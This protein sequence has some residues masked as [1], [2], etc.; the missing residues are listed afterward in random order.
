MKRYT[1]WTC[2]FT[3][4]EKGP[5]MPLLDMMRKDPRFGV[6][7]YNFTGKNITLDFLS[8]HFAAVEPDAV[9]CGF[10]RPEMVPVAYAAYHANIPVAQIFA[11]DLAGGAW[12]DADRFAISQYASMLFVSG[13]AQK[14]RLEKA[15]SWR[16]EMNDMPEIVLSGATH[17]DDLDM[18]PPP[19]SC[20]AKDYNVV[21]YNPPSRL[22]AEGIKKELDEILGLVEDDITLWFEPN[23]DRLSDMI[24]DYVGA[25]EKKNI[26][27]RKNLDRNRF[28][29]YLMYC[30]KFIG[31]SSAMFYEGR[32]FPCEK[33]QVGVRNAY[34]EP[35]EP[36][37]ARAGASKNISEGLYNYLERKNAGVD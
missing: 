13:K 7:S 29:G 27:F 6:M 23:G 8:E 30:K 22:D 26:V 1:I 35:M 31:N 33:V 18:V 37:Y 20:I 19:A 9:I 28:L 2:Y 4:S 32:A 21:L 5:L 36:G 10:D 16:K 11:G 17:F 34:R 15:L 14:R 24:M 3:R 12:D 25:K